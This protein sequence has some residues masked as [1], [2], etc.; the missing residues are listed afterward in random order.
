[1][2]ISPHMRLSDLVERMY[3]NGDPPDTAES[4]ARAMRALLVERA[5]AYG[6]TDTLDVD[7]S[8]WF[9]M[10]HLAVAQP[11]EN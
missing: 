2:H 10:L 3:V 5:P 1:M 6:W 4:E 8:D 11:V 7:D 9:R